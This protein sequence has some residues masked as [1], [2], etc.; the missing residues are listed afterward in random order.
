MP[1]NVEMVEFL[2]TLQMNGSVLQFWWH[3]LF[4]LKL[5]YLRQKLIMNRNYRPWHSFQF[6]K[7]HILVSLY[8]LASLITLC[9]RGRVGLWSITQAIS[10]LTDTFK[11]SNWNFKGE[12]IFKV[13]HVYCDKAKQGYG[14]LKGNIF[15]FFNSKM[16]F[17]ESL[18]K[19]FKPFRLL[20][21]LL[22]LKWIVKL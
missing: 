15:R 17:K 13:K 8:F 10:F 7:T 20:I 9:G 16:F 5:S 18:L 4:L 22:N 3:H 1:N 11:L 21:K 6:K 12:N 2:Y 14:L 19:T